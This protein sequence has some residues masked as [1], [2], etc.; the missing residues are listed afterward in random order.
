M[1]ILSRYMNANVRDHVDPLTGEVNATGLAEDAFWHF[2]PG[3]DDIEIP[4]IYF[5]LAER[6]ATAYE[7]KTGVREGRIGSGLSGLI[8]SLPSDYF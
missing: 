4:D 6:I 2:H 5:D 3:P 7:I 1:S 8:S